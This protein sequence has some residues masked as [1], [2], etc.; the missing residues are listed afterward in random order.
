MGRTWT[1][2]LAALVLG[3][4][5]LGPLFSEKRGWPAHPTQLAAH[6]PWTS[7][8]QPSDCSMGLQAAP[9]PPTCR[10]AAAVRQCHRL[11]P[12][13]CGRLCCRLQPFHPQVQPRAS[14]QGLSQHCCLGLLHSGSCHTQPVCPP[15]S[16]SNRGC[17]PRCACHGGE[18]HRRRRHSWGSR[19]AVSRVPGEPD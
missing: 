14:I 9:R 4:I 7:A 19:P 2:P 11:R 1:A 3:L 5:V 10:A 16:R 18:P 6:A 13:R 15:M 8:R 17:T 12:L